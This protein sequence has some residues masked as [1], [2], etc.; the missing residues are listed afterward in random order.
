MPQEACPRGPTGP[1]KAVQQCL[2][3]HEQGFLASHVEQ[4]ALTA[5]KSHPCCC[6]LYMWSAARTFEAI[7]PP[8][9][10]AAAAAAFVIDLAI[11]GW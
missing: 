8:P 7:S 6:G 1:Q 4:D 9:P 3:R 10:P 5:F 11:H 2:L